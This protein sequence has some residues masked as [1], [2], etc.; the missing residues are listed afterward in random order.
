MPNERSTR[1][2]GSAPYDDTLEPDRALTTAAR[3]GARLGAPIY[4]YNV[5]PET[6]EGRR[7]QDESRRN[8]RAV[9]QGFLTGAWR[10]SHLASN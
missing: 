2:R 3:T 1:F 8:M 5:V 4:L 6:S 9:A 7:S 10:S